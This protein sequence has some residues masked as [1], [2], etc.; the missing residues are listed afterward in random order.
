[1]IGD[2]SG[3]S[4]ERNLLSP[5]AVRENIRGVRN[6]LEHFM[7]FNCGKNSALIVNNYDWLKD[8]SFLDFLREV[9]KFFTINYMVNKEHVKS[10][11]NDPEKSI[12]YTEFSYT[13]LQAY[14]FMHLLEKYGCKY[15][16][17]VMTNR[18]YCVWHRSFANEGDQIWMT[19]PSSS[20]GTK[21]G[22]TEVQFGLILNGHHTV[23]T[24][25]DQHRSSRKAFK[26][27]HIPSA[28]RN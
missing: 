1:M 20:S 27:F 28:G 21:F 13:L 26:I 25:S 3:K 6:Q 16:W 18:E 8:I 14:D 7:N 23:F 2:P 12:S 19:N 22:K 15:R 5:E 10:R 9:G 11:L 17:A 4:K 24:S